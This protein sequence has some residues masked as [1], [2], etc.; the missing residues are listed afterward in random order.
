MWWKVAFL[1]KLDEC[2]VVKGQ[3]LERFSLT[4]MN[5]T[6]DDIDVEVGPNTTVERKNECFGVQS[7][8]NIWWWLSFCIPHETHDALR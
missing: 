3:H 7:E 8:K 5:K 6:L 4:M 2:Q 1:L